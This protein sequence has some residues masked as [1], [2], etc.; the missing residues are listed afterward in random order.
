MSLSKINSTI[1]KPI[2]NFTLNVV[3]PIAATAIFWSFLDNVVKILAVLVLTTMFLKNIGVDVDIVKRIKNS[4]LRH[5]LL[6]IFR[7]STP[8][9]KMDEKYFEDTS[10]MLAEGAIAV[11]KATNKMK[12]EITNMNKFNALRKE[13]LLYLTNNKKTILSLIVFTLFFIDYFF[14]F[15]NKY[16]I[17]KEAFY[18]IAGS[19][20]V[21]IL[22]AIGGEGFTGNVINRIRSES[23]IAKKE[24]NRIVKK[25]R[26]ELKKKESRK[27]YLLTFAIN[28]SLPPDKHKE[29]T[30]VMQDINFY[31][32][33][34][35][36]LLA[37]IEKS[38]EDDEEPE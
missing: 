29:Y 9:A 15:T 32:N 35:D 22:W 18:T 7:S 3:M 19:I 6:F 20:Y 17:P 33:E 24:T 38:S 36:K 26:N 34:I 30:Q 21:L 27:A 13:L 5:L 37:S 14:N 4:K 31:T 11:A 23:K 8:V 12:E 1:L 16:G 10:K 25:Y 28:D 2:L